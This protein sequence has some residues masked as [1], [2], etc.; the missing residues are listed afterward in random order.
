MHHRVHAQAAKGSSKSP[1][2]AV[3]GSTVLRGCWQR[4]G[5]CLQG[6]VLVG[7]G[8]L[9][10]QVQA[11]QHPGAEGLEQGGGECKG[12][13]VLLV[14]VRKQEAPVAGRHEGRVRQRRGIRQILG[15]LQQQLPCRAL[16]VP[17]RWASSAAGRRPVMQ[18]CRY[19]WCGVATPASCRV[20]LSCR[21]LPMGLP[22]LPCP[23]QLP[24][25]SR[26]RPTALLHDCP[27]EAPSCKASTCP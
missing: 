23:R 20:H 6:L 12:A 2:S 1:P 8:D 14:Q 27:A 17:V 16:G 3:S 19:P 13:A 21:G 25:R 24:D 5:P 26:S 4:K 18:A 15:P 10:G 11:L 9:E 7:L 22:W